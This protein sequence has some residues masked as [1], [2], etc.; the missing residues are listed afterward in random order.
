MSS[1]QIEDFT[2]FFNDKDYIK[3]K[4]YLFNY[5]NRKRLIRF[6]SKKYPIQGRIIDIGCG[7][8]PV[9]PS[10]Q[11]TLFIDISRSALEV[12]K[13]KGYKTAPGSITNLPLKDNSVDI[14][15]CSEVLEHIEDYK[16]AL[17]EISRVMAEEG[18]VFITVPCWQ[19]F[20]DIDDEFVGHYRRFNPPEFKK[21]I[22]EQGLRIV[23][24]KTIGSRL[25]R[26]LTTLLVKQ[27]KKNTEKK[28]RPVPI[29]I[30]L[31]YILSWIIT[32][33]KFLSSEKSS[34]ILLFICKKK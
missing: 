17:K 7:I 20:W 5:L 32:F 1:Q 19:K 31:N 26:R 22:E 30:I 25:E 24:R 9:T 2:R 11:K 15:F 33:S 21:D 14:I 3:L 18:L 27:F 10:P 6:Y 16:K 28:P 29:Y 4:N 34:S 23:E 13:K 12:L 8:S